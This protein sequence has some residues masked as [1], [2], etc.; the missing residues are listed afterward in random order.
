MYRVFFFF[1]LVIGEYRMPQEKAVK[2]FNLPNDLISKL[3]EFKKVKSVN[4]S[5]WAEKVIR[6]ALEKELGGLKTDVEA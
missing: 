6:K 1:L 2:G 3:A 4:L 5:D